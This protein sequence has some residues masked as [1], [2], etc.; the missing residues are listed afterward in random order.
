MITKWSK[1]CD[2]AFNCQT[3]FLDVNTEKNSP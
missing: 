2:M 1:R 3:S